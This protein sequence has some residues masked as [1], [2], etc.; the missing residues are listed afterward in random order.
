MATFKFGRPARRSTHTWP[1]VAS[2]L[3]VTAIIVAAATAARWLF[4]EYLNV[5]PPFTTFF[6]AII[7][8]AL[9]NGAAYGALATIACGIIG[10]YYF[11]PPAGSLGVTDTGVTVTLLLFIVT[12]FGISA[13][14]EILIRTQEA[15]SAAEQRLLAASLSKAELRL[16]A[17]MDAIPVG[18]GYSTSPSCSV[19]VGNPTLRHQFE[20]A[21]DDNASASAPDPAAAGRQV[22]FFLDGRE[23][24]DHEL[25]LQ[26]AVAERQKIEPCDFDVLL[27]SGRRWILEASAAPITARDG[28][29]L[30]GVAVAIDVT[31]R[32]RIE[33]SLR[34][35]DQRK[36]EFLA[37][38]AHELRNPL[39][40]IQNAFLAMQRAPGEATT[41]R[42][43]GIMERQL[44]LLVRIVDDLLDISRINS[45]KIE[46]QKQSVDLNSIAQQAID[47]VELNFREKKQSIGYAAPD[48]RIVI[49][50]DPARLLQI[51][52]N[53][54]GNAA[55]FTPQSGR[56]YLTLDSITVTCD[57]QRSRRRLRNTGGTS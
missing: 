21:P 40:A 39:A 13:L 2:H 14:A 47:V 12:G 33:R 8:V 50:A 5:Q 30:G 3:V 9:F 53:I 25:P 28:A 35:A 6:P 32:R 48:E 10:D 31:Q 52:I 41:A 20:F 49:E 15:A 34:E 18:I 37:L 45:K 26:R 54:L 44:G 7:I 55:K 17:I 57:H 23:I 42:I 36:E 16:Q 46:L 29:L 51:L 19:I 11:L 1:D 22:R 4:G 43:N 56:L 24:G 38:L 27:P